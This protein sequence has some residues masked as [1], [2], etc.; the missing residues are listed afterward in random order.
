MDGSFSSNIFGFD[1]LGSNLEINGIHGAWERHKVLLGLDSQMMDTQ[2]SQCVG[3]TA[4][5]SC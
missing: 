2:V 4:F 1:V 3:A 5:W